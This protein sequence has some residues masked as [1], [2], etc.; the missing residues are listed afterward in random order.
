[1]LLLEKRT[2]TQSQTGPQPGAEA[3]RKPLQKGHWGAENNFGGGPGMMWKGGTASRRGS[4]SKGS[5]DGSACKSE[6]EKK[7]KGPGSGG[8]KLGSQGLPARCGV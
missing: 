6:E 8:E 3:V 4:H 7:R 5:E 1:M 2:A